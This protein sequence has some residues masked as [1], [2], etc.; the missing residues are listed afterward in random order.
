[1]PDN[2]PLQ[3][4]GFANNFFVTIAQIWCTIMGPKFSYTCKLVTGFLVCGVCMC[5]I[6]FTARMPENENYFITFSVLLVFGWFSGMVQGT[7]YTM[8]AAMGFKYLGMLF[9][10]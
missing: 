4:F 3:T 10:G 2:N 7:A 8:A 1:M 9:L 5:I 6:P